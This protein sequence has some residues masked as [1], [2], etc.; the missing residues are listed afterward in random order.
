MMNS[1]AHCDRATCLRLDRHR[2]A[3]VKARCA[4]CARPELGGAAQGVVDSRLP[5]RASRTKVLDHIGVEP[6]GYLAFGIW[7]RWS[8]ARAFD[9]FRHARIRPI[10]TGADQP[11]AVIEVGARGHLPRQLWPIIWIK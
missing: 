10:L 7:R 11:V 8:A 2:P 4:S 6:Q 1:G 5:P 3:S 9:G